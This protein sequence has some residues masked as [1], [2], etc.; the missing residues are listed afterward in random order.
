V[1]A[2]RLR[3]PAPTRLAVAVPSLLALSLGA[4][5]CSGSTPPSADAASSETTAEGFGTPAQ[6]AAA[7]FADLD[8]SGA[9]GCAAAVS[10]D[11]EVVFADGFGT[12]DLGNG[13]PITPTTRFDIASV[14]K[15]I[16][17]ATTLVLVENGVIALEDS[18]ATWLPELPESWGDVTVDDLLHHTS[19][20]PSYEDALAEQIPETGSSTP[21]DA[22][23][24]LVAQPDLTFEP[25]TAWEYSN[26][27]YFLLSLIVARATGEEFADVVASQVLEPVGMDDTFVRTDW[28]EP[29]EDGAAGYVQTG[30][31]E[32]EP[33]ESRWAQQGD[34]AVQSTVLDLLRWVDEWRTAAALGDAVQREMQTPV[35]LDDGTAQ[36]YGAGLELTTDGQGRT[37]VG[38]SG[39]W[40][41]SSSLVVLY[42]DE[43]VG[44]AITCNIDDDDTLDARMD[45]LLGIWLD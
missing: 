5:A 32:F 38:H 7:V 27:G 42:P 4:A 11:G 17:A 30:E 33:Y 40:L 34:G 35:V 2:S 28:D 13:T 1:T 14:S 36:D 9:P 43:S 15:S 8:G 20:L 10:V 19:G 26:S 18:I 24:V 41:G 31:G 45:E 44:G 25:G 6:A 37:V 12:A 3:R 16:T 22:L 21:E 29:V 23:A 39:A